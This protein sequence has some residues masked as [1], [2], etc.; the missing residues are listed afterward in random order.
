MRDEGRR[1]PA[2]PPSLPSPL[3]TRTPELAETRIAEYCGPESRADRGRRRAVT[4][5][6][7]DALIAPRA[8]A[9]RDALV[10]ASVVIGVDCRDRRCRRRVDRAL[11]IL[12]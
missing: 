6:A 1:C 2:G 8:A 11:Q 10:R 3:V 5:T 9:A 12:E 7:A 4:A